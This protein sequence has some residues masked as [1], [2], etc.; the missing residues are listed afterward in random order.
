MSRFPRHKS[1][2]SQ[3][4]YQ[5]RL[6]KML[7]FIYSHYHEHIT[8]KDIAC[9]GNVSRS[10][11]GRCFKIF[12]NCSPVEFLIQYRL[13]IAGKMLSEKIYTVKEVSCLCGFNSV[14]YFRR[15]FKAEYGVVPG[16]VS[17]LG[18]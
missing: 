13:R 16:K 1:N 5:I 11:A 3:L 10:E 6:Q 4:L 12:M 14:N 17:F 7:D 8:L 18:K 9:A 15:R 2:R